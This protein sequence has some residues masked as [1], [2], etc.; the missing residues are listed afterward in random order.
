MVA[1][2]DHF[3]EEEVWSMIK[4]LLP[5]K[6]LARTGSLPIFLGWLEDN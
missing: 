1:L 2:E 3:P 5:N 6:A 4:T